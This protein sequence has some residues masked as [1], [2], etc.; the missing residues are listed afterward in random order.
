MKM[1]EYGAY[2]KATV[3]NCGL[4]PGLKEGRKN[5]QSQ[6]DVQTI[7]FNRSDWAFESIC[8]VSDNDKAGGKHSTI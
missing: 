7:Y 1:T 3:R 5:T 4:F 6:R 8:L 2:S